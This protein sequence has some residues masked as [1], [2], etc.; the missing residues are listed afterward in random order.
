MYKIVETKV[1]IRIKNYNHMNFLQY[2]S[3]SDSDINIFDDC[4]DDQEMIQDE[5]LKSYLVWIIYSLLF[6]IF[7]SLC[8]LI[9]L[10]IYYFR[11]WGECNIS[12][13]C[14]LWELWDL[15]KALKL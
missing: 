3:E 13:L 14:D 9:F 5:S 11:P 8:V 15:C 12:V 6:I 7:L 10:F 4:V 1:C 2:E